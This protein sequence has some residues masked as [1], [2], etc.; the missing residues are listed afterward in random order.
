VI[1]FSD[2]PDTF[3]SENATQLVMWTIRERSRFIVTWVSH[4][5]WK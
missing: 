4:Q 3:G 5:Y 1:T 2:Q